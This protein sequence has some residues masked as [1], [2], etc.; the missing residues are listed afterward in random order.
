LGKIL[1]ESCKAQGKFVKVDWQVCSRIGS[2]KQE[3]VQ[4][5]LAILTICSEDSEK[6]TSR[7]AI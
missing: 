6:N 1:N 7:T 2:R 4:E 5:K 3:N